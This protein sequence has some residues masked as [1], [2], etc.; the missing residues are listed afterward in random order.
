MDAANSPACNDKDSLFENIPDELK[1]Y[2]QWVTFRFGPRK[3][4]GKL[5]K[6]P[7]SP[8]PGSAA[9]VSNSST[10]ATFDEAVNAFR[11]G[12]FAGIGFVFTENDPFTG[13]DLDGCRNP[14]TG[15]LES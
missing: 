6:I 7:F 8:R 4:N 9:S 5:D 12:N 14:Q 10:W 11:S 13:V 1:A 3:A 15:H 2:P